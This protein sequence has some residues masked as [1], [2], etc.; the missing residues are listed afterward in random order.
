MIIAPLYFRL[1]ARFLPFCIFLFSLNVCCRF[2]C[3]VAICAD[4]FETCTGWCDELGYIYKL[5]FKKFASSETF[6]VLYFPPNHLYTLIHSSYSDCPCCGEA[7]WS[8]ICCPAPAAPSCI[9]IICSCWGDSCNCKERYKR[10]RGMTVL[11]LFKL[12]YRYLLNFAIRSNDLLDDLDPAELL[13]L[14]LLL[15]QI[16]SLQH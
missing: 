7:V 3:Y 16:Y 1:I 15:L 6:S 11:L 8:T 14:L 10:W 12:T 9:R 2:E 4:I 5:F 13:L